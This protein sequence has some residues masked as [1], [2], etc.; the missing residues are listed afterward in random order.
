MIPFDKRHQFNLSF[1]DY[2]FNNTKNAEAYTSFASETNLHDIYIS[3]NTNTMP[4]HSQ[5]YNVA[6]V[7]HEI[8]HAYFDILYGIPK[9]GNPMLVPDQHEYIADNYINM[10]TKDLMSIFPNL[11]ENDARNLSWGGLQNT[12]LFNRLAPSTQNEIVKI[13]TLYS[14]KSTN[15]A[16]SKGSYCP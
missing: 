11:S 4:S 8:L 2:P 14:T 9:P 12:N 13:N 6:T 5:E 10:L 3:F 15:T 7:Y 16:I 1:Q